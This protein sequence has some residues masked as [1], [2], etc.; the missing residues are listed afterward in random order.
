[1][2]LSKD[3][4]EILEDL[5]DET[6]MTDIIDTLAVIAHEKA[7]HIE[8]VRLAT[9]WNRMGDLLDKL[10]PQLHRLDPNL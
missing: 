1:M 3:N 2:A 10:M 7:E 6:N 5:V 9:D 4:E 8:D